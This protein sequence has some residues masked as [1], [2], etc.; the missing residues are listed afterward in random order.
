MPT[1]EMYETVHGQSMEHAHARLM[2][3]LAVQHPD[4]AA[5]YRDRRAHM[6]DIHQ[7]RPM[8]QD[9]AEADARQILRHI[10]VDPAVAAHKPWLVFWID[11][12]DAGQRAWLF[13]G[14]V[15]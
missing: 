4:W 12:E 14:W 1:I 3:S 7:D 15:A 2:A 8:P 10:S 5:V 13:F 9:E 6:A 11:T